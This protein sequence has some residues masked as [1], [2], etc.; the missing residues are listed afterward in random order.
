MYAVLVGNII[1]GMRL[2][3]TWAKKADAEMWAKAEADAGNFEGSYW[4]VI[5]IDSPM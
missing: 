4:G 2:F 5:F 3:G 1:E